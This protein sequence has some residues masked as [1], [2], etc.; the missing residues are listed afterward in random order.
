MLY[1]KFL[2]HKEK[3]S[4]F[5]F[6][7]KYFKQ[8]KDVEYKDFLRSTG[9]GL[10]L[11]TEAHK[12]LSYFFLTKPEMMD[13]FLFDA[14]HNF[15]LNLGQLVRVTSFDRSLLSYLSNY[16]SSTDRLN[17][18][19]TLFSFS[20]AT[21]IRDR[22]KQPPTKM[23]LFPDQYLPVLTLLDSKSSPSKKVEK[24]VLLTTQTTDKSISDSIA[25]ILRDLQW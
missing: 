23:K 6:D 8:E 9:Q 19:S 22:T 2:T 7:A 21:L 24:P 4:T 20:L 10:D 5:F 12:T 1:I 25:K 3:D 17:T 14:T 18:V 13:Q 15:I 11:I 16:Y